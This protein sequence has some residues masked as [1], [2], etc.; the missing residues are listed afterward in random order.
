MLKNTSTTSLDGIGSVW[1]LFPTFLKN[2]VFC[3]LLYL[4]RGK[5]V[6]KV[7]ALTPIFLPTFV[8]RMKSRSWCPHFFFKFRTILNIFEKSLCIINRMSIDVILKK[9]LVLLCLSI[10]SSE[11]KRK[12]GH[13]DR[14]VCT[15]KA[16]KSSNFFIRVYLSVF[17]TIFAGG[18]QVR[19]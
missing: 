17:C 4:L 11:I 8:I 16:C 1:I 9:K 10:Y 19:D 3:N 15:K 2:I 12:G 13:L 7:A 14:L 5:H 6:R 18:H